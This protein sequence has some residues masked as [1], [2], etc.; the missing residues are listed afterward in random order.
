ME[1][2]RRALRPPLE[3]AWIDRY[4][5]DDRARVIVSDQG[6]RAMPA[7]EMRGADRCNKEA[8]LQLR[9]LGGTVLEPHRQ[10]DNL[11]ADVARFEPELL[12]GL[13]R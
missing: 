7:L 1:V 5:A 6:N 13:L 3:A 8:I 10:A 9:I 11:L 2:G 12:S 4:L